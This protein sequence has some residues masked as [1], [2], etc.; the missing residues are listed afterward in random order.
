VWLLDFEG[1]AGY[2]YNVAGNS[3]GLSGSFAR[4]SQKG[5]TGATFTPEYDVYLNLPITAKGPKNSPSISF[6]GVAGKGIT[7]RGA[8]GT[9]RFRSN[10]TGTY[11]IV[12]DTNRD[13]SLNLRLD[14]FP[15]NGTLQVRD[16][17]PK[18][19]GVSENRRQPRG[20][21]KRAAETVSAN[22]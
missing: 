10:I 2:V 21:A 5:S 17:T 11:Q 6:E 1:M 18:E 16:W 13:G 3:L 12:I 19:E 9:F 4:T 22:A 20:R 8:G 15:V 14:A 7:L